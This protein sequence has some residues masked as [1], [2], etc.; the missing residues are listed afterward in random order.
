MN[1]ND[2]DQQ[3]FRIGTSTDN[4]ELYYDDSANSL[5]L[6]TVNN[7]VTSSVSKSL[8]G[9]SKGNDS[10]IRVAFNYVREE[11]NTDVAEGLLEISVN[12]TSTAS[13][14]TV[15]YLVDFANK[16]M[17]LCNKNGSSHFSGWLREIVYYPKAQSNLNLLSKVSQ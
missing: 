5:V 3:I 10:V 11:S 17:Y 6:S 1:T 8:A 15:P 9:I 13:N 14:A 16:T 2:L 12:G 7:S 4:L